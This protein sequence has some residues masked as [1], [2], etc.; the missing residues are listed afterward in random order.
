MVESQVMTPSLPSLNAFT[1]ASSG[2]H[3]VVGT[4]PNL[5]QRRELYEV[6]VGHVHLSSSKLE[7]ACSDAE[8]EVSKSL[9]PKNQLRIVGCE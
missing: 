2:E 3:I 5:V 8:G 9:I 7:R 4:E 1:F 6:G